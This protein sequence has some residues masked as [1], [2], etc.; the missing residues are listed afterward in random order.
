MKVALAVL[1][2]AGTGRGFLQARAGGG[3]AELAEE[4]R[5]ALG[6]LQPK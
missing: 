2:L 5:R 4:A 3:D 6:K 1:A